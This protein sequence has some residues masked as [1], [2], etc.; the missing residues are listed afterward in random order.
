MNNHHRANDEASLASEQ[1]PRTLG[2]AMGSGAVFVPQ[3]EVYEIWEGQWVLCFG[4]RLPQVWWV[5][6]IVDFS[7]FSLPPGSACQSPDLAHGRFQF[8]FESDGEVG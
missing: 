1:P 4:S 7:T 8:V 3:A 6:L 2:F 5:L